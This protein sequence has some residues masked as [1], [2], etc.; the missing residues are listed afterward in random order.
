MPQYCDCGFVL[1]RVR[2]STASRCGCCVTVQRCVGLF[3]RLI[4]RICESRCAACTRALPPLY[5]VR[6][7]LRCACVV[8]G[9]GGR[10]QSVLR[11]SATRVPMSQSQCRTTAVVYELAATASPWWKCCVCGVAALDAA[12][13]GRGRVCNAAP[14]LCV[15][16]VL[17]STLSVQCGGVCICGTA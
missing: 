2:R 14:P 9:C 13:R 3:Q 8:G 11:T 1:S 17:T 5:S 16:T 4:A 6:A 15:A 10:W 7:V 12:A